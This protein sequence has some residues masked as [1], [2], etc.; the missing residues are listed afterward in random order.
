MRI[1]KLLIILQLFGVELE[2]LIFPGMIWKTIN[3]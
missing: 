1:F 3:R 2:S